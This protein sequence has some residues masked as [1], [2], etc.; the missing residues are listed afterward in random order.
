[1]VAS[2]PLS[3]LGNF[4]AAVIAISIART[5]IS[6]DFVSVFYQNDFSSTKKHIKIRGLPGGV[7]GRVA[8]ESSQDGIDQ[9]ISSFEAATGI[10]NS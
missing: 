3:S 8:L 9:H 1:M 2:L 6:S 5:L 4:A 10:S 7:Q